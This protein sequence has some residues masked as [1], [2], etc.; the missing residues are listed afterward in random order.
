MMPQL[1]SKYLLLS[2]ALDLI[3]E[4]ARPYAKNSLRVLAA[5]SELDV[6][7]RKRADYAYGEM[8]HGNFGKLEE[9][10]LRDGQW[11]WKDDTIIFDP[12]NPSDPGGDYSVIF[13]DVGFNRAEIDRVLGGSTFSR[14]RAAQEQREQ[15][16]RTIKSIAEDLARE[17]EFTSQNKF[18]QALVVEVE[19][20]L[21]AEAPGRTTLFKDPD[22]KPIA[23]Q[24]IK[25][26]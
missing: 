14:F 18:L 6:F 4:R 17:G 26:K 9:I 15:K 3:D 12:Q 11:N 8:C 1:A 19:E 16:K 22:I 24:F 2:E 20:E 13:I 21:G 5:R 25:G 7:G 23:A 10:V